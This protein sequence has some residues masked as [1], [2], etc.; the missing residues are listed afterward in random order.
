MGIMLVWAVAAVGTG[1]HARGVARPPV[2]RAAPIRL[3]LLDWMLDAP[4]APPLE[5]LCRSEGWD[6][7]LR[8]R[9]DSGASGR[10]AGDSG[11][12][13]DSAE[14]PPA[15]RVALEVHWRSVPVE[16]GLAKPPPAT[17]CAQK[18][19]SPGAPSG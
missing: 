16:A 11:R 1:L 14:R 19:C 12:L 5:Q 18:R 15:S 3:G 9:D 4:Y 8:L 7:V 2:G 13:G 10:D 17:A 6:C